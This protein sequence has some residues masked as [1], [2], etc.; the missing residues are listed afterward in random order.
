MA[1][2]RRLSNGGAMARTG[3]GVRA[4]TVMAQLHFVV[5]ELL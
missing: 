2:F 3:S 4:M 5:V 1:D